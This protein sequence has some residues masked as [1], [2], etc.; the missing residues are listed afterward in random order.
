MVYFKLGTN[1]YLKRQLSDLSKKLN[2]DEKLLNYI[3][4]G[5][6][7]VVKQDNGELEAG[8]IVTFEEYN[9][10]RKDKNISFEEGTYFGAEAIDKL[11]AFYNVKSGSFNMFNIPIEVFFD[12]PVKDWC[13]L[14]SYIATLYRRNERL[15][16]FIKSKAPRCIIINEINMIK[17]WIEMLEFGLLIKDVFDNI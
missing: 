6:L 7:Y 12:S 9:A 16:K 11:C 17:D 8:D 4:D 3:D 5:I 14:T 2:I 13:D 15:K 10:A 1:I